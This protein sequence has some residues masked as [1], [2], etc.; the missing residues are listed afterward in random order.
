MNFQFNKFLIL[1]LFLL[2]LSCVGK[3]EKAF[4]FVQLCDTQ[5]GFNTDNYENDVDV[6]K[7][8]VSQI[9]IL[10]PDF[11]VICGDLVNN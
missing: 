9:N 10:N 4:S 3:Q 7:R 2:N 5:L 11:V 6:F 1:V 8:A